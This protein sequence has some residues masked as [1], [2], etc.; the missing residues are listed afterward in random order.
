M[1]RKGGGR[2]RGKQEQEAYET[3]GHFRFPYE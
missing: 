2:Q 3:K 1:L